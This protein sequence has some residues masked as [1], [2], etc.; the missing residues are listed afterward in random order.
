[1]ASS[2]DALG[3]RCNHGGATGMEVR[4]QLSINSMSSELRT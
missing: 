2:L 3:L 1:M 4:S